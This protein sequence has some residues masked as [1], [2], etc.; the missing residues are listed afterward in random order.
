MAY[1][2][3]QYYLITKYFQDEAA[4]LIFLLIKQEILLMGECLITLNFVIML[5]YET[6]KPTLMIIL[7]QM[8]WYFYLSDFALKQLIHRPFKLEIKLIASGK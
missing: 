4:K 1:I 7:V 2:K 3:L 6:V 8:I 5:V